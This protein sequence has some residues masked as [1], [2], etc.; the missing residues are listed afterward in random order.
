MCLHTSIKCYLVRSY[1]P[2]NEPPIRKTK[3]LKE[4]RHTTRS[5][6]LLTNPAKRGLYNYTPSLVPLVASATIKQCDRWLNTPLQ[7]AALKVYDSSRRPSRTSL[8]ITNNRSHST[9]A[10]ELSWYP[11]ESGIIPHSLVVCMYLYVFATPK[12]GCDDTSTWSP[13]TMPNMQER[14]RIHQ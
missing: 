9:R 1:L 7:A 14:I 5:W 10:H 13:M 6:F 2:H 4:P 8:L 3:T 11:D 12:A